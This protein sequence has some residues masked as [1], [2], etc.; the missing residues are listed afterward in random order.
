MLGV[1]T[2][3]RGQENYAATIESTGIKYPVARD[4]DLKTI[5]PENGWVVKWY[6]TYVI[7]DKKGIVRASGLFNDEGTEE[8]IKKLLA[9]EVEEEGGGTDDGGDAPMA[10]GVEI[11]ADFLE[12]RDDRELIQTLAGN[13]APALTVANWMNTD[14]P[15]DLADLAGKVVM[16]DYWATW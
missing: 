14:S 9:E 12:P 3:N 7:V 6:P 5:A 13:P 11:P 15:I 10:G 8:I 4:P 2:S 16:I 1:C